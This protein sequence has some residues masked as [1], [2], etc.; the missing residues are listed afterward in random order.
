MGNAALLAKLYPTLFHMAHAGAWPGI[1]RHGLLSTSALL[2]LFEVKGARRDALE[3]ERRGQAEEVLHPVY[4]RALLRDQKPL[5][6]KKL[7]GA[8][9]DG[10]SVHDWYRLLNRRVF[11][12][13]PV[14]RLGAL[15]QAS[16]YEAHRQTI[17]VVHTVKLIAR[18]A[19][20]VSLCH[21]NSGATR[22][23]AFPRGI[24]TFL[25]LDD[26][27]LIERRKRGIKKAV[28]EVTVLHAVPD[29][30]ILSPRSTKSAA[31]RSAWISFRQ[32]CLSTL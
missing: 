27:P 28:A 15:R 21:M 11:F 26:Y 18:R 17:L 5:N 24:N 16:E 6:E 7:A 3:C 1:Q 9:K 14:S 13:G 31:E 2:D 20:R 25:S 30:A 12:W 29:I 10:L 23:M 19:D 32:N 4:G 22:P 8:L